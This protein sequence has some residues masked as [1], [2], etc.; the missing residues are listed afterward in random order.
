VHL[1]VLRA[2]ALR[3]A[4]AFCRELGGSS[5]QLVVTDS[6]IDPVAVPAGG[7]R[8]L[9]SRGHLGALP[10][11]ER[12]AL[13]LHE[14]AHL[15]DRHHLYRLAAD[16]AGALDPLQ[17]PVRRAV[18]YATERWAD[19][20]AAAAVGDRAVVASA[21]ARSGLRTTG[22]RPGA[23]W[24]EVALSAGG[25]D[26]VR[27]VHALLAPAPRQ[28]PGLV[29]AAGVVVA[30]TLTVSLHAQ[31]DSEHYFRPAVGVAAD[32]NAGTAH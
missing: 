24:E 9:A 23:R 4:R 30:C 19:E 31:E 26:V 8:I 15:A 12:R 18:H 27:R 14:S 32:G 17:R 28:R 2:R 20:V 7:G 13:L 1:A 25:P 11:P 16:L 29:L 10:A 6:D 21:L 5:G 22:R 3:A